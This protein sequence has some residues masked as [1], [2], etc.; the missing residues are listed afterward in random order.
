MVAVRAMSNLTLSLA[1]SKYHPIFIEGMG[2]YDPRDPS[3]VA[4][5]VVSQL[6]SHFQNQA[7]PIEKPKLVIIQGDPLNEKG[8]SAITLQV[9]NLLQVPRGLICLDEHI[10]PTHIQN[11]DRENVI[12][13]F[14]Y[15][16]MANILEELNGNHGTLAKLERQID[17]LILEKNEQ[18]KT[19]GKSPLKDYFRNFALLQ[20]VT[21]ASCRQIC[22]DITV[23]HT[24]KDI[25]PFSVTSFY[26]AGLDLGLVDKDQMVPFKM[27][28]TLDFDKIDKR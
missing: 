21:K 11:A 20:E 1:L 10:Y 26:Q 8:I 23:A 28:D 24:A 14:R 7:T 9:S 13:E 19:V 12:L 6:Q 16:Q 25:S 18:R 27:D 17:N 22:G 4:N 5:H 15:S 3:I 2:Y